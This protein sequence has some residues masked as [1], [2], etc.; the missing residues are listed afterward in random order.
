MKAESVFPSRLPFVRVDLVAALL[1]AVHFA[2]PARFP[3][4]GVL[5]MPICG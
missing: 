2:P 1:T 3:S 4:D 5:P